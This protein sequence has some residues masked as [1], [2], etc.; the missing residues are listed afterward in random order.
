MADQALHLNTSYPFPTLLQDF[1]HQRLDSIGQWLPDPGIILE[2]ILAA[3][4]LH[5]SAVMNEHSPVSQDS[6]EPLGQQRYGLLT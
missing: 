4:K 1:K 3:L 6:L 2:P 5:A